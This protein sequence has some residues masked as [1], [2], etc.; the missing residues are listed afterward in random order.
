MT[1]NKDILTVETGIICHQVNCMGVMGS[2]LA[3]GIRNKW[4]EVYEAYLRFAEAGKLVLSSIQ[5]VSIN[6]QLAVANLAGQYRYGRGKHTDY[7]ALRRCLRKLENL[8]H[9]TLQDPNFPIYIPYGMGCGLGGGD[10]KIVEAMI[11]KE[12]PDAIIC[13][14]G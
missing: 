9:N 14:K 3:K 10:W 8:R 12:I 1:I 11:Y 5:L 7:A 13:K 4:P 2:G 6:D